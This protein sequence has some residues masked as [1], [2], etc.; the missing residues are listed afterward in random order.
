MVNNTM[1]V[2]WDILA[3]NGIIHAIETPLLVPLR[4]GHV[5]VG[6]WLIYDSLWW[7]CSSVKQKSH[8]YNYEK[9]LIPPACPVD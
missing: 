9:V 2:E 3:S 7:I 5:Q 6:C 4:R 1:I 8:G